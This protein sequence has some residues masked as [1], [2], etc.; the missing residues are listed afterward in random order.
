MRDELVEW[1]GMECRLDVGAG[2]KCSP[3]LAKSAKRLLEKVLDMKL[4]PS[5]AGLSAGPRGCITLADLCAC[6]LFV[7]FIAVLLGSDKF[8]AVNDF[9][10]HGYV[11]ADKLCDCRDF[12]YDAS[13]DRLMYNAGAGPEKLPGDGSADELY[14]HLKSSRLDLTRLVEAEQVVLFYGVNSQTGKAIFPLAL[15]CVPPHALRP[16]EFFLRA[17]KKQ[18]Y[19]NLTACLG[20]DDHP[21]QPERLKDRLDTRM[22]K[23][24]SDNLYDDLYQRWRE[25]VAPDKWL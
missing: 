18:G 7:H 16:L 2:A 21:F 6:D 14:E 24:L 17:Q 19:E 11:A 13:A 5:L 12:Y 22:C 8:A 9:P 25:I 1:F 10:N 3:P 23:L 15:T 4:T 20:S